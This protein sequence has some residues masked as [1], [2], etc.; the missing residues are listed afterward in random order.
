MARDWYIHPSIIYAMY[1]Y[2]TN[3]WQFYGKHIPQMDAALELINTH[4]FE[5]E[6]LM[7]SV[8]KIKELIY[9]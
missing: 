9:N 6:T 2:K 3:E 1:C 5:R 4:P 7:E 8:A